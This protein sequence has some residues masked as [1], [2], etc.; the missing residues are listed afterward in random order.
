[1]SILNNDV[2]VHIASFCDLKETYH[3]LVICYQ[4]IN[5]IIAA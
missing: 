3:M 1:M 4:R 5:N 2:I